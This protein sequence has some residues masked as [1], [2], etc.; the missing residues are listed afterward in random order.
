MAMRFRVTVR[1]LNV[2]DTQTDRETDGGLLQYLPSRAFGAAGDKKHCNHKVGTLKCSKYKY[3]ISCEIGEAITEG[4]V[5][6]LK[7]LPGNNNS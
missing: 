3:L 5:G 6:P 1:K 2:M 7:L 4:I